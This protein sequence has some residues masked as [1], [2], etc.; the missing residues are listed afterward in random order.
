MRE[1]GPQGGPLSPLM[2]L[3][4]LDPLLRRLRALQRP[5]DLASAWADDLAAV[6]ASLLSLIAVFMCILLYSDVS[7]LHLQLG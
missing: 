4:G 5:R 2:F 6:C 3:L 1:G 7:G